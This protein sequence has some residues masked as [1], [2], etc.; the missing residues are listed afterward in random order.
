M[1]AA[2]VLIDNHDDISEKSDNM[3]FSTVHLYLV[4]EKVN[5]RL[6]RKLPQMILPFEL[7]IRL[8]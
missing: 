6:N 4:D 2:T 3:T 5:C 7:M 1:N 8:Y